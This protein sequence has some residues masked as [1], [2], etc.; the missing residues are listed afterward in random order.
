[1]RLFPNRARSH[2][3]L[4]T[5]SIG[6]VALA[7]P[8]LAAQES[9][10]T[11]ILLDT[12]TVETGAGTGTSRLEGFVPSVTATATKT[13][14]PLLETPQ[15]VS[16]VGTTQ[17]EE[18]GAQTVSEAMNYVPGV[19]TFGSGDATG[20]SLSTRGFRLDPYYGN[21]FRDGL[22]MQVNIFDG[23]Q[24]VY[25]LERIELLRGPSSVLYGQSG[26]AG[27][28]NTVSK[29]PTDYPLREVNLEYGSFDWKQISADVGGPIDAEGVFTW[30]LTGL[31]RDADTFVD[32]VP[33]DRTYL[34]PAFRWQPDAQTSLTLLGFYQNDESAY[35]YGLPFAG[36]VDPNPNGSIPRGRNLGEPGYD[37]YHGKQWAAT[38]IF[39]HDFSDA[40]SFTSSARY[41][42]SDTD[43]PAV[44][45][46]GLLPDQRTIAYRAAQDR[47]DWSE[48]VTSDNRIVY[49]WNAGGVRHSTLAGFDASYGTHQTKRWNRTA[50]PIDIFDPVYGK[51]LGD[52]VPVAWS[53]R[54]RMDRYGLYLQDQMWIG[55]NWVAT[56]GGRQ[57]W[58]DYSS[59]S[60][61]TGEQTVDGEKSDAFTGRA[62]IVYL[63][64]NGV[65]PYLS[66]SQSFEPETGVNRLGERLQPTRGEQTETGMRWQV[67]GRDL[68]LSA[69]LYQI[70][71]TNVSVSDPVDP[72]FSVQQGEVRSRGLELEA[73]G[74]VTDS[75]SL[76]LTYAYTDARTTLSSPLTPDQQGKRTG[77]VPYNQASL[78]ADYDFAKLPGLSAGFGVRYIGEMT[79]A[80]ADASIPAY[81][82]LDATAA[83]T[84]GDWQ[85]RLNA[86]NLTDKTYVASCTYACFFGAPR[87]VTLTASYRW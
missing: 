79:A 72:N 50:A 86:T 48:G 52:P 12:I 70:T 77:N 80:Y 53:S 46:E 85:V 54:D 66:W 41:Y 26:P 42:R 17:I 2:P 58:V 23:Q 10:E 28:L 33:N 55:E 87:T 44:W 40:L 18:T 56:I 9:P 65:A 83:Y 31:V 69:A 74:S 1:M 84:R 43:M 15:S 8:P 78:W 14:T 35:V 13:D 81:T 60:V 61:F 64:P 62:G 73:R 29:R 82:L 47:T 49:D 6:L 57:D 22:R 36:T 7:C 34:A 32:F 63:A 21:V 51:P 37:T 59:W 45:S 75:L 38:Y 71:Q 24:E 11:G 39:E 76:I 4:L 25:G 19:T 68:M 3:L 27:V 20:D 67:P 5:T 30:R 16:V